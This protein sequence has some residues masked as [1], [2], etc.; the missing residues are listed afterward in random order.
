MHTGYVPAGVLI[1]FAGIYHLRVSS[2]YA[3]GIA[4]FGVTIAAAGA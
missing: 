1:K 3:V 4:V 2:L